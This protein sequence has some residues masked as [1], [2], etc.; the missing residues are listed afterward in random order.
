[1]VQ[2]APANHGD[3]FI[4]VGVYCFEGMH[5]GHCKLTIQALNVQNTDGSGARQ[6]RFM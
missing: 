6:E 4:F 2:Q 3:D 5:Q 1:M